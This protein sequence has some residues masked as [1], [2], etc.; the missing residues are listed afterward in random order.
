MIKSVNVCVTDSTD[1]M[2][3]TS[4]DG[5]LLIIIGSVA[6]LLVVILVTVVLTVNRY[7]K[8]KNKELAIELNEKR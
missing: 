8:R 5:L 1:S 6:T 7:Y 3:R 2:P 4:F